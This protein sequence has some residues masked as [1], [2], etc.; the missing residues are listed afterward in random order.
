MSKKNDNQI[1]LRAS[2]SFQ[3][4]PANPKTMTTTI[5]N[6]KIAPVNLSII[7]STAVSLGSGI[8]LLIPNLVS[9]PE[10]VITE[11]LRHLVETD[12]ILGHLRKTDRILVK[13]NC[14][15]FI[16]VEF[17]RAHSIVNFDKEVHDKLPFESIIM[18]R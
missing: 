11:I 1:T 18:Q 13:I 17:A 2:V 3:M 9:F 5:W 4:L 12:W 10:S 7:A 16:L 14:E 6:K 8:P 15:T